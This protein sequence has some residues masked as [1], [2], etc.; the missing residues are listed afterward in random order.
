[1]NPHRISIVGTGYVGLCTAIAFATKGYKII[2]STH[3]PEKAA[4]INKGIPPF[5]EPGL[6]NSLQKVVQNGNLKCTLDPEE[7]ILNTDITFIAT[8][9]PKP[10][11]RKHQLTT[12]KKLS[13]RNWRSPKQKRRVSFSGGKKHSRARHHRKRG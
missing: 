1:M 10:T 3:N 6:Q 11:K 2:T 13:P 5:Y 8:A 12:R 9:T 4:L 7:A